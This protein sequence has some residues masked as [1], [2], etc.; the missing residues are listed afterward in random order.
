[1]KD[2]N[3]KLSDRG[4]YVAL[5]LMIAHLA[6]YVAILILT[7]TIGVIL[8]TSAV[9]LPTF[10]WPTL[11]F[12]AIPVAV[13][14]FAELYSLWRMVSLGNIVIHGL[15]ETEVRW[16]LY[17]KHPWNLLLPGLAAVLFTVWDI[18]L[19]LKII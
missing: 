3:K 5:Y 6:A 18:L 8:S 16:L 14:V 15:P 13:L 17:M 1:M 2:D 11:L 9:Q 12:V 10:H 7:I 4:F 19:V